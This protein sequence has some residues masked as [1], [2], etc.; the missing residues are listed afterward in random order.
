LP[1]LLR[2]YLRS[3]TFYVAHPIRF[4][5]PSS[6]PRSDVPLA[7]SIG[8]MQRSNYGGGGGVG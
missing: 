4:I 5:H 8:Y 3:F 7:S 6:L 2:C 1:T